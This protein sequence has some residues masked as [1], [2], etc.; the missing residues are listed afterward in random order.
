MNCCFS[1]FPCFSLLNN[2]RKALFSA[3]IKLTSKHLFN[4]ELVS[5][6]LIHKVSGYCLCVSFT[7]IL[8]NP[9]T[10]HFKKFVNSLC[11]KTQ[12]RSFKAKTVPLEGTKLHEESSSFLKS[13][14]L[15]EHWLGNLG[16]SLQ[17]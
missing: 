13:F 12:L 1:A 14:C 7:E 17:I 4:K 10:K 15:L 16:W 9:R 3:E 8:F 6:F 5:F 2:E 11:F